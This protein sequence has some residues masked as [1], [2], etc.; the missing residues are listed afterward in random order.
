MSQGAIRLGDRH[1]GG[2]VMI[3]ASGFPVNGAAQCLIGDKAVCPAH[4]GTFPLVEG[5]SMGAIHNGRPMA[6]EPARLAC[7]CSVASSCVGQYA[8]V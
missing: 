1:S 7:G 3:E 6:F 8:R 4:K 2:G 5:G